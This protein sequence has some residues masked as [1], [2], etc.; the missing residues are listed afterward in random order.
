EMVDAGG[1]LRAEIARH[2]DAAQPF[3]ARREPYLLYPDHKPAAVAF[4]GGH[5]SGKTSIIVE[6][7]PRLVARGLRVGTLK[8]STPD[9]ADDVAGKDPERPPAAGAALGALGP[10]RR[11]TCRRFGEQEPLEK[12]LRRDFADCDLVLVEG[13]KSLPVPKIEVV[14]QGVSRPDVFDP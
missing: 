14:R 5:D 11:T 4:V 3:F 13:Y 9:A 6:L 8:H 2:Y 7:V 10:P 1:N 12:I